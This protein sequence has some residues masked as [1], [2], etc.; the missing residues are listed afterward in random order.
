[1]AA[2]PPPQSPLINTNGIT[3]VLTRCGASPQQRVAIIKEGF[4]GMADLLFIE[5][6][7]MKKMMSNITK[8]RQNQ[9]GL[10]IRAVSTKKVQA[11]VF[12]AKE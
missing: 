11:L 12:W 3:L 1:M 8:L 5:E 9:G 4:T 2:V 7:D 6:S 10:R